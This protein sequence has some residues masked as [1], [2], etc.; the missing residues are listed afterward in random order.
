MKQSVQLDYIQPQN[1]ASPQNQSSSFQAPPLGHL[2]A[3]NM[4]AQKEPNNF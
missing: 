2:G 3:H 1:L 4:K